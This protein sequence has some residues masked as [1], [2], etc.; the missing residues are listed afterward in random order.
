MKI[1]YSDALTT[2]SKINDDFLAKIATVAFNGNKMSGHKTITEHKQYFFFVG[3][4][5]V[6]HAVELN[7]DK[8][9]ADPLTILMVVFRGHSIFHFGNLEFAKC[10]NVLW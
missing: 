2:N 10:T 8:A 1:I 3:I 9:I 6:L 4:Y 7:D 5:I